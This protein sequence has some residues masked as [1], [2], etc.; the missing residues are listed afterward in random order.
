MLG[1]LDQHAGAVNP[2]WNCLE[3]HADRST[4]CLASAIVELAVVLWAFDRE[5]HHQTIT[6]MHVF[7]GAL[8]RRGIKM[9]VH[10]VVD[11]LSGTCVVKADQVFLVNVFSGTGVNPGHG[12]LLSVG[13]H[14]ARH[15]LM[16][17]FAIWFG[18]RWQV[19]LDE[20]ILVPHLSFQSRPHLGKACRN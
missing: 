5:I 15:I 2:D 14:H 19:T 7:M 12:L 1:H 8:P 9:A 3:V 16:E 18:G 20:K 13:G 4:F 6:E 10:P 17:I 11:R